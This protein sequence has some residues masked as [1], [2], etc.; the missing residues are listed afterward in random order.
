MGVAPPPTNRRQRQVRGP[1]GQG[2]AG[3]WRG[4]GGSVQGVVPH[5]DGRHATTHTLCLHVHTEP[6][7]RESQSLVHKSPK[8]KKAECPSTGERFK[9]PGVSGPS[10]H[11]GG[12]ARD[13]H[14]CHLSRVN[15]SAGSPR[16]TLFSGRPQ[17]QTTQENRVRVARGAAGRCAWSRWQEPPQ[18]SP[19]HRAPLTLGTSADAPVTLLTSTVCCSSLTRGKEH[20]P[21]FTLFTVFVTSCESVI[22]TK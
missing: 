5:K 12:G 7:P 4:A 11:S 13:G 18:Q 3:G 6:L 17:N 19:W 8:A 16:R 1:G 20:D 2:G 14:G 21:L 22:T 10:A 9:K 15:L